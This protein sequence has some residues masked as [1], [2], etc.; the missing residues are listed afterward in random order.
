VG[1]HGRRWIA[2]STL[3]GLLGAV[4]LAAGCFAPVAA[5]PSGGATTL[6]DSGSI[7]ARLILVAAL[8]SFAL[9]LLRRGRGLLFTGT[10]AGM[11]VIVEFSA[12]QGELVVV[13]GSNSSASA[14]LSSFANE[15]GWALLAMG[16][17]LLLLAGVFSG[18]RPA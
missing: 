3:W 13:T 8:S 9:I 11:M 6:I 2:R 12:Y 10:V 14:I 7:L 15:W 5:L 16:I 1:R 17:G 4:A 18:R